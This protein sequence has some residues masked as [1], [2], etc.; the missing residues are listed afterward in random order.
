MDDSKPESKRGFRWWWRVAAVVGVFVALVALEAWHAAS[1]ARRDFEKTWA[2]LV[3][4]GEKLTATELEDEWDSSGI[5]GG[6]AFNDVVVRI[7][8]RPPDVRPAGMVLYGARSVW[9]KRIPVGKAFCTTRQRALPFDSFAAGR[10][11]SSNIWTAIEP[12]VEANRDY[13]ADLRRVLTNGVISSPFSGTNEVKPY[14]T[15]INQFNKATALSRDLVLLDLSRGEYRRAMSHLADASMLLVKWRD[16]RSMLSPMFRMRCASDL[17]GPLWEALRHDSWRD[18]EL[19]RLQKQWELMDFCGNAI[20]SVEWERAGYMDWLKRYQAD[21]GQL[22]ARYRYS[23]VLDA[24][25]LLHEAVTNALSDPDRA[26]QAL[27]DSQAIRSWASHTSYED[28]RWFLLHSQK[29]LDAIRSRDRSL[30]LRSAAAGGLVTMSEGFEIPRAYL[31]SRGAGLVG[32]GRIAMRLLAMDARR[33]MAVTAIALERYR[34]RHGDYPL[35]LADLVPGL[36]KSEPRDWLS[37]GDALRYERLADGRFRLWSVG[38]DGVDAGG[39]FSIGV[40]AASKLGSLKSYRGWDRENDWVWPIP[41]LPD[42]RDKVVKALREAW[43][44]RA[45]P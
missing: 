10:S 22:W 6:S 24:G 31:Y 20:V 1:Q 14:F 38:E 42:R 5:D 37:F 30:L 33:E 25:Q 39:T 35:S 7:G 17:L 4:R 19:A 41:V 18:A 28:G 13:V 44:N 11:W 26:F 8:A 32:D 45:G 15:F 3:A 9:R 12:F 40:T 29:T 43:A 23:E 27:R 21:M 36:L 2:E 16:D 34:M